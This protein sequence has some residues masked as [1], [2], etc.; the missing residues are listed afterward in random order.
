MGGVKYHEGQV[1]YQ[2]AKRVLIDIDY[3]VK[4]GGNRTVFAEVMVNNAG[5]MPPSSR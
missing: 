1:Q 4:C 2:T 5:D 3:I